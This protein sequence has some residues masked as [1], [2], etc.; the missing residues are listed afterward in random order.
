MS[1]YQY[2]DCEHG[3]TENLVLLIADSNGKITK[4]N[5]IHKKYLNIHPQNLIVSYLFKYIKQSDKNVFYFSLLVFMCLI[6]KDTCTV[7]W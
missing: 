6:L 5:K 4:H 1:N 3:H 2:F 7:Y